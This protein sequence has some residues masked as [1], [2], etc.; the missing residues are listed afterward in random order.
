MCA[1][2]YY[3]AGHRQL[4]KYGPMIVQETDV[5]QTDGGNLVNLGGGFNGYDNSVDYNTNSAAYELDGLKAQSGGSEVGWYGDPHQQAMPPKPAAIAAADDSVP[6][7]SRKPTSF[8]M[9]K[10][11]ML[12]MIKIGLAK[13][14]A[15]KVLKFLAFLA[16]KLKMLLVWKLFMFVKLALAFKFFKLFVM[17]FLP[18]ML[19]WLKNSAMMQ[20]S[21]SPPNMDMPMMPMSPSEMNM[22]R[23]DSN[24]ESVHK[25]STNFDVD[26]SAPS[27]RPNLIEFMFAVQTAK[28]VEKLACQV[29]GTKPL[30]INSVWMNW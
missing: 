30:N 27:D 28:C 18:N 12:A 21:P 22:Y 9:Q 10:L 29:A 24:P 3:P 13:L 15:L 25:R 7:P 16:V 20:M 11:T 14:K 1:N 26:R 17:P 2:R 6:Q 8:D 5:S 19:L 4:K 23:N